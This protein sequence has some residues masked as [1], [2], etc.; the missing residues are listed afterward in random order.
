[1]G[2]SITGGFVYRGTALGAFYQGRY[3][4]ADYVAKRIWSLALTINPSDGA[5]TASN[6]IEHTAELGGAAAL[7]N[8]SA[9][10]VDADGEL[11]IVS[12]TLGAILKVTVPGATLPTVT[13]QPGKLWG[14]CQPSCCVLRGGERNAGAG[15]SMAG[16]DERGRV[17]D[18]SL[19]RRTV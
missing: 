15:V 6:L 12:H 9:F 10:G 4:F 8:V 19:E 5:A 14:A 13:S 7:G 11:Y 18:Q 16:V 2:Q 17:V 1:M 3:F